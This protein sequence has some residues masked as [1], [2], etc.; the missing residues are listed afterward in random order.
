MNRGI[1]HNHHFIVCTGVSELSLSIILNLIWG[2]F[3]KVLHSPPFLI[4]KLTHA[5]ILF[6]KRRHVSDKE[7]CYHSSMFFSILESHLLALMQVIMTIKIKVLTMMSS[8]MAS[9]HYQ[10]IHLDLMLRRKNNT[11]TNKLLQQ[12]R[13]CK[14]G[15]TLTICIAHA[16]G[17]TYSTIKLMTTTVPVLKWMCKTRKRINGKDHIVLAVISCNQLL[18]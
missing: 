13:C 18:K 6:L 2:V 9:C 1:V 4:K 14:V 15:W 11:H 17:I 12:K 3:H 16:N 7:M 8:I 10:N 5:R